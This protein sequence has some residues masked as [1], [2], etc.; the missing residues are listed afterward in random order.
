[1]F[2]TLLYHHVDCR[3]STGLAVPEKAFDAQLAHLRR[4]GYPVLTLAEVLRIV[5]GEALA[6]ERAVFLTLDDGYADNLHKALP[7]LREH[8]AEATMFVPTAHVGASNAWNA[9]ASYEARHLDWR[10][11]EQW[12]EGGGRIGGHTHSHESAQ[13]V[14]R[15]EFRASIELNRRLLEERLGIEVAAFAYPYGHVTEEARAEVSLQYDVAWVVEGGT[16]EPRRDRF[17]LNRH[18]VGPHLGMR[19]FAY[20]L[21]AL[22]DRLATGKTRLLRRQRDRAGAPTPR[23]IVR[24]QPGGPRVALVTGAREDGAWHAPAARFADLLADGWDVHLLLHGDDVQAEPELD[25]LPDEVLRERVHPPP[26]VLRRRRPRP[27]LLL[28]LLRA[29]A[30]RPGRTLAEL[31]RPGDPLARYLRAVLLALRPKLV[32]FLSAGEEAS[33]LGLA[34]VAGSRPITA[35]AVAALGPVVDRSLFDWAAP[36]G[37]RPSLHVAAVGPLEWQHGFEYLLHSL[38]LLADGGVRCECRFVGSGDHENAVSFA[39]HQLDLNDAVELYAPGGREAFLEH[40]RWADVVVDPAVVPTKP[41][42][43]LD[44]YAAGRAVVTTQLPAGDEGPA[45]VVPPRDPEALAETLAG[46]ARDGGL[47]SR[48][49]G[50]GRRHASQ[51]DDIDWHLAS[52]RELCRRTL[53]A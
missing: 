9:R 51:F 40:L 25:D 14:S 22:F 33:W 17:L 38:R 48:L 45:L 34:R 6:P 53:D 11:L 21:D 7:L 32:C 26:R 42:W 20:E 15:D 8:G 24:R 13:E 12:L 28:G 4:E 19:D 52:F 43:L 1:M 18:F 3:L 30:R 16:W 31:R 37:N 41:P 47:R 35:E 39:R 10:E 27:A 50:E 46:L 44:A 5:S 29:A 49:A 36:N 2:V 23:R